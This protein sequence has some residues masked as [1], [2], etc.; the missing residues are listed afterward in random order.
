MRHRPN[1]ALAVPGLALAAVTLLAGCSGG[2]ASTS[3]SS[4]AAR[5]AAPGTEAHGAAGT[6]PIGYAAPR[7]ARAGDSGR[8]ASNGRPAS[9]TRVA[10]SGPQLVYTAQLSVRA[11]NVG[12]AVTRATQI[13]TDDG[14]YVAAE[15]ASSD[16]A[17]PSQ[18]TA[19][20]SLKIPV[21][22]YAAT[23]AQLDGGVL[24]TRLSLRQQ[25]ADVTRQAAD[26]GS[27]VAS[28]R[29]AIAQLRSLL[30]HAGS[31]GD[32]LD[33]QNQINSEESD[34]ESLEAQQNA[35]DHET[36]FATVTVTILGPRAAPRQHAHRPPPGLASG[37]S[38]GWHAFVT[39]LDWL[40]AIIGAVAP[41]AAA[42]AA[43]GGLG[44]W[45]RRRRVRQ[46]GAGTLTPGP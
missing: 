16:P 23:L 28:D 24:G 45:L 15:N 31:V 32:L 18:S 44:Y 20:V 36:A 1:I 3:S 10:R 25:T 37:L 40:G 39:A 11:R 9:N 46:A 35:L 27:Q 29:A 33:V 42:T 2:P 21:T 8:T 38:D 6:A 14:G 43:L 19:T 26:V 13:V 12:D 17:H 30:S 5:A 34:L 7:N 22:G 41:F 4:S